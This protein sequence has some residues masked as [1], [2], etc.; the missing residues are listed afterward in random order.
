MAVADTSVEQQTPEATR[1]LERERRWRLI[2]RI[3]AAI[4]FAVLIVFSIIVGVP[5]D[6]EGVLVWTVVGLSTQCLGRGWRSF[7][8]ILLDWLPFTAALV[9]YDYTRGLANKLGIATHV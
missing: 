3:A 8:R 6:R 4:F 9:A 7:L 5:E 1:E 2:R